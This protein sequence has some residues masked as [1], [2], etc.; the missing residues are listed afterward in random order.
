MK[1]S[2]VCAIALLGILSWRSPALADA[3][4]FESGDAQ[5]RFDLQLLNDANV[6]RYPLN[7][8][9]IPRAAVSHA[10]A[11]AKDHAATNTAV[12]EALERVRARMA[13]FDTAG[14]GFSA[15]ARGGDPGLLRDFDSIAR[16]DLELGGSFLYDAGPIS[17]T[18]SLTGVA[19][20]VDGQ[21]FRPD[22]SH[23][24]VQW[25][26]WLISANTLDR[27]WGPGH[28]GSLILSSNARPLPTLM[29]ER[30][31]A[32]PFESPLLSWLGP[33]RFSFGISQME[34]DRQDVASP[35]FMAWR[36]A[37]MP[38]K[39]IEIGFSRTA[40]FCGDGR[41]CDA[42]SFWDMLIG[43]DNPG[44]DSTTQTEP[45]NQMAGFDLHW[46]SPLGSLPYAIYGQYIG[47]DE[48]S[49][50]PAKYLG[51]LGIEGW[52]PFAR[53]DIL[54]WFAEYANTTCSALSSSGPYYACAYNQS[55]FDIEGYRYRG[56]VIG[57]TVDS[58]AESYAI[59]AKYAAVNGAL[60][61]L[62]GRFARLNHDGIDP[63]N[64]VSAGPADYAALEFAWRGTLF[65]ERVSV[66]LGAEAYMPAGGS[67]DLE[68]FGF[69][70]WRHDF[71]V[72]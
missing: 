28:E 60:W 42:S 15:V 43:N 12:A 39:D 45:G 10:L 58:D 54:Q 69:F 72:R 2:V 65:G 19:D 1:W 13:A 50:L 66:E 26:N 21:E 4:W 51:Q 56:R 35:L 27:W 55:A 53:G 9:P 44:F 22:G 71:G 33:W 7:Q 46:N 20:P 14:M 47:E 41:R 6:I 5:F 52:K 64:T 70:G 30:A 24:T 25:G 49:F 63:R 8:W 36:V 59:G 48:S 62:T 61:S 3:G 38:H 57:H 37:I 31:A 18:L 17:A 23:I 40:Q 29:V 16:E 11:N 67:R 32:R 34:E 68:P